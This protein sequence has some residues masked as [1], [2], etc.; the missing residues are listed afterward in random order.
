MGVRFLLHSPAKH[1]TLEIMDF[2]KETN[3]V[4]VLSWSSGHIYK[5]PYDKEAWAKAGWQREKIEDD[6]HDPDMV[7]NRL[8]GYNTG[9]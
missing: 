8:V 5:M 2:L 4:L 9:S 3:E 6:G 7:D 1:V